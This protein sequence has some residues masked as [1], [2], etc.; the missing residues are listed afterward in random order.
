MHPII[1]EVALQDFLR[2]SENFLWILCQHSKLQHIPFLLNQLETFKSRHF[3]EYGIDCQRLKPYS[4]FKHK[5]II[6]SP[7]NLQPW[8]ITAAAT[9]LMMHDNPITHL[10][11]YE[12]LYLISQIRE[13]DFS[14]LRSV[15]HRTVIFVNRLYHDPFVIDMQMP[16]YTLMTH[17][18]A[19]RTGIIG[20]YISAE[21]ISQFFPHLISQQF[22]ACHHNSRRYMKAAGSLLICQKLQAAGISA[23]H[24]RRKA[25]QF[26]HNFCGRRSDV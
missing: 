24:D 13:K 7:F 9:F 6:I 14:G 15:R 21:C 10:V 23:Q 1:P 16:V 25:V 20:L 8:R 11:T 22:S 3:P 18:P 17:C 2:L 19:F 26:L 12:R 5:D 4:L